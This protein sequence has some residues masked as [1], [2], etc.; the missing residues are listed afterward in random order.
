VLRQVHSAGTGTQCWDRYIVLRQGKQEE[1]ASEE[2]HDLYFSLI[3]YSGDKIMDVEYGTY[4]G[5]DKCV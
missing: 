5:E 2:L 4:R 3:Y 1:V